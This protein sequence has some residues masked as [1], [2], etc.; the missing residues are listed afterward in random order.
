MWPLAAAAGDGLGRTGACVQVSTDVVGQQR[1][2]GV[3]G[4]FGTQ[5]TQLT[6]AAQVVPMLSVLMG[7]GWGATANNRGP[8][9]LEAHLMGVHATIVQGG[10]VGQSPGWP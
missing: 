10:L 5:S 6:R 1:E 7:R 9:P 4:G 8:S 3:A 2:R